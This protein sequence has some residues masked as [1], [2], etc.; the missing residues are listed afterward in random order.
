MKI[1][2][3][4]E[5]IDLRPD[6]EKVE[7]FVFSTPR[8]EEALIRIADALEWFIVRQKEQDRRLE[9][10][11]QATVQDILAGRTVE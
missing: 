2:H 5:R 8:L 10:M 1:T 11:Q 9:V 6:E 7:P 3:P 4:V